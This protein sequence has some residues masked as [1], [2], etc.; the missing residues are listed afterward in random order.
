MALKA[1]M[2]PTLRRIGREIADYVA[3][4]GFRRSEFALVGAWSERTGRI[5][6]VLGTTKD[7]DGSRWYSD[8]L[9]RLRESFTQAG[10]PYATWHVG[11]VI[12]TIE[13][14]DQLYSSFRVNDDEEDVTDFLESTIDAAWA[15]RK[16]ASASAADP[17]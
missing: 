8:I 9:A 10:D 16:P 6:L 7:V 1:Y 13:N 3:L 4:Q 5:S 12:R 15:D 11:L 14:E 2:R 17:H